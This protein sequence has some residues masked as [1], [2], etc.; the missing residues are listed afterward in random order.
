M[1][2]PKNKIVI[3]SLVLFILALAGHFSLLYRVPWLG[4]FTRHYVFYLL[5]SGYV[6]L[7]MAIYLF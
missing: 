3:L 2:K 4:P 7:L 6:L 1:A 5:A